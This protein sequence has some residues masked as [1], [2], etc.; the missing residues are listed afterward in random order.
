[1]ACIEFQE[2]FKTWT[3]QFRGVAPRLSWSTAVLEQP[4]SEG[5]TSTPNGN[6]FLQVTRV[7]E[8]Y[9]KFLT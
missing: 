3:P 2:R 6:T 5:H 1:M 4:N 9:V 7:T 8:R